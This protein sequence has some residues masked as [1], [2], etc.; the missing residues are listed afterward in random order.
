MTGT[1]HVGILKHQFLHYI[2]RKIVLVI[3]HYQNNFKHN[4]WFFA[5]VI[6]QQA[7]YNFFNTGISL[8]IIS[9]YF[10]VQIEMFVTFSNQL[11]AFLPWVADSLAGQVH[12]EALA[13][14]H[15]RLVARAESRALRRR[16]IH[17]Q[18]HVGLDST[19]EK[20]LVDYRLILG[21]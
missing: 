1:Q 4:S 11:N 8:I 7:R 14:A 13:T 9:N 19:K 10:T 16:D 5:S 20:N 18:L 21:P 12:L 2:T 15:P 17:K 3:F 6:W